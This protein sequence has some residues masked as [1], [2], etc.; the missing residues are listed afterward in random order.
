MRV[1]HIST[2]HLGFIQ[3]W[4]LCDADEW[5]GVHEGPRSLALSS[6]DDPDRAALVPQLNASGTAVLQFTGRIAYSKGA[7]LLGM[8]EA[9]WEALTPGS[10]RVRALSGPLSTARALCVCSSPALPLRVCI[11]LW[12][13]CIGRLTVRRVCKRC[14]FSLCMLVKS[15]GNTPS[16]SCMISLHILCAPLPSTTDHI[17][18]SSAGALTGNLWP[19]SGPFDLCALWCIDCS[20]TPGS[21]PWHPLYS[22]S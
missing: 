9:Y 2:N 3:L 13:V 22:P 14:V 10:F 11:A 5:L 12:G 19:F 16:P 1:H 8:L 6:D 4:T 20:P 21:L 18:E 15:V 7:A 17:S